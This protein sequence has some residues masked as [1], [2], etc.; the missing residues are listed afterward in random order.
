MFIRLRI[1][2]LGLLGLALMTGGAWAEGFS[3]QGNVKGPDGKPVSG[4]SVRIEQKNAKAMLNDA[5]TDRKG[6]YGFKGLAPGTY[7][8]TAWVNNVPTSI[9][10]VKTRPEGAVRVDFDIKP[11]AAK[12]AGKKVKH[13]VW[14]PARTGSHVGGG[15]AEVDDGSGVFG[16]HPIDQ[17]SGEALQRMPNHAR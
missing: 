5:K 6:N 14:V 10:N 1:I 2:A 12:T 17:V 11:T 3:I 13:L 8:L 4:A 7:K 15:W 9:D 16:T